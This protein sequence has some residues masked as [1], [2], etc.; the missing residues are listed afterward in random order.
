M[1]LVSDGDIVSFI[2]V[3]IMTVILIWNR[4]FYQ[5]IFSFFNK[6]LSAELIGLVF[7]S[8]TFEMCMECGDEYVFFSIVYIDEI[9]VIIVSF[10]KIKPNRF[11][12]E[13][14]FSIQHCTSS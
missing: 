2:A 3:L 7:W 12:Y 10:V 13:G 14:P 6:C 4:R 11:I 9:R 5:Q 1:L 8:D